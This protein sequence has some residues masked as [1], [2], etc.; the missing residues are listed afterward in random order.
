MEREY[1]DD[2]LRRL[3]TDLAN[4]LEGWDDVEIADY[5]LLVQ[6][7]RAAQ[8][9]ADLRNMRVLRLRPEDGCP[10]TARARLGSAREIVLRFKSLS[11]HVAVTFELQAATSKA[12]R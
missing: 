6:C 5:R 9:D 1:L 4:R 10:E 2:V 12:P 11:G 3:A 7:A 8:A